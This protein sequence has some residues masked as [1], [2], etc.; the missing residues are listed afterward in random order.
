MAVGLM[1]VREGVKNPDMWVNSA[2]K[3]NLHPKHR[4]HFSQ[5]LQEIEGFLEGGKSFKLGDYSTDI[6]PLLPSLWHS[7]LPSEKRSVMSIVERNGGYNPEC[8]RELYYEAH[9]PYADMQKLRLCVSAALESPHHLDMGMPD[10]TTA[11]ANVAPER[12]SAV[13]AQLPV[14]HG[15]A[16]FQL[17]PPGLTDE[18]LFA[19]MVTFRAHHSTQGEPSTYLEIDVSPDQKTILNP[20]AQQLTVQAILKDAG[21]AGATKKL[22]KRKLNTSGAFTSH[23]GLQNHPGRVKKMLSAMELT[24]SMAEVSAASKANKD[25]DQRMANTELMDLAPAALLKLNCDKL[26][27]DVSKMTKKKICAISFRFF[28]RLYKESESKPKLVACLEGL[29]S[30]QPDVLPEAAESAAA[31]IPVVLAP[32]ASPAAAENEEDEES[33]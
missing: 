28:G 19:H 29:I 15:L 2:I 5:R 1:A 13:A 3:V 32:T 9:V 31:A 22:A 24:A 17:K 23:C 30:D 7:M 16:T 18:A 27:G 11:D 10:A 25:N 4:R 21:G 20:T 14:T 6:Y 12:A 33:E 8:V 26:N